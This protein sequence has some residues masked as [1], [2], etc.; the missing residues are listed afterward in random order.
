M[1]KQLAGKLDNIYRHDVVVTES[2]LEEG[3]SNL[4]DTTNLRRAFHKLV[5]GTTHL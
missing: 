2:M 5:T 1:H 4:G 3:L